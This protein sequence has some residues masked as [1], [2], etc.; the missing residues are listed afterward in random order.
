[1]TEHEQ[2]NGIVLVLI[3]VSEF[4]SF[5]LMGKKGEEEEM[6]SLPHGFT[7]YEKSNNK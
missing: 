7:N 1:M 3:K 6:S 5:L 2:Y 4:T